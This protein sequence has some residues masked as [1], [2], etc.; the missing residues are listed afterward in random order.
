MSTTIVNGKGQITVPTK[1]RRALNISAG[2]KIHFVEIDA[3][4]FEIFAATR[5]V[6]ELKGMFGK[7]RKTVSIAKM[8]TATA[9]RGASA[10]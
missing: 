6:T 3:G 4:R 1:I 2:D 8:N 7:P 10:K 5:P 9:A